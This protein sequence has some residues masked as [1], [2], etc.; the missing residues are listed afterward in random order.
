MTKLDFT[1][2]L[3]SEHLPEEAEYALFVEAETRLRKLADGHTDLVGAAINIQRVRFGETAVLH[4]VTV[5]VY[6]RPDHVAAT[7]KDTDPRRALRG[8]LDAVERQV[9]DRREKL[10]KRWEQPGNLPVEQEI[11]TIQAAQSSVPRDYEG[12]PKAISRSKE[13]DTIDRA[14]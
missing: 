12:E 10:K 7:E 14:S 3:T 1:L 11:E 9:R 8:A 4:E 13:R 5:V 6:S 2:E